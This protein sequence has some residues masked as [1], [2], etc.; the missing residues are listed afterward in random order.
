[1]VDVSSDVRAWR[2]DTSNDLR[3]DFEPRIDFN[4]G[5]ARGHRMTDIIVCTV[6]EPKRQQSECVLQCVDI[7]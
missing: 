7:P 5:K 3:D 1:M 6:L 4:V 2:L